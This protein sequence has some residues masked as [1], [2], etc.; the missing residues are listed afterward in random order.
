MRKLLALLALA[1]LG[2]CALPRVW[3]PECTGAEQVWSMAIEL[4][5]L[6]LLARTEIYATVANE[7]A[8]ADMHEASIA[9]ERLPEYQEN[10]LKSGG[11]ASLAAHLDIGGKRATLRPHLLRHIVWSQ[12]N[13]VTDASFNEFSLIIHRGALADF[14][15]V[16]RQR[17]LRLFHE[18]LG[19]FGVLGL[20][21][22][23]QPGDAI[24]PS[25]R[26][27]VEGQPWYKRIA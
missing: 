11:R 16:L 14:G 20:D 17:V 27:L 2:G 1:S 21:A 4:E 22:P 3:L 15:P 5:E 19:R 13:L 24:A 12:S 18:S 9:V 8:L 23:L 25:Y 7:Q 6:R 10:Y 26:A